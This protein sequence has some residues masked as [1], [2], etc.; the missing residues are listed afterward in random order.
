MKSTSIL[1]LSLLSPPSTSA[2]HLRTQPALDV[3]T[4]SKQDNIYQ[5]LFAAHDATVLSSTASSSSPH[6]DITAPRFQSTASTSSSNIALTPLESSIPACVECEQE[7]GRLAGL[8]SPLPESPYFSNKNPIFNPKWGS[9]GHWKWLHQAGDGDLHHTSLLKQGTT[10]ERGANYG[11]A[12]KYE[13]NMWS[14]KGTMTISSDEVPNIM[15]LSAAIAAAADVDRRYVSIRE[16][17]R[18]MN[19]GVDASRANPVIETSVQHAEE[20]MSSTG[21]SDGSSATGV[22]LASELEKGTEETEQQVTEPEHNTKVIAE[23][24]DE[25][26]SETNSETGVDGTTS[27]TATAGSEDVIA[28]FPIAADVTQSK[29]APLSPAQKM[30]GSVVESAVDSAKAEIGGLIPTIEG[31]IEK[32]EKELEGK[33]EKAEESLVPKDAPIHNN[34]EQEIASMTAS[35][36]SLQREVTDGKTATG[37]SVAATTSLVEEGALDT[38][39]ISVAPSV[40]QCLPLEKVPGCKG[41]GKQYRSATS[42]FVTEKYDTLSATI[43][44][45]APFGPLLQPMLGGCAL[46]VI[47]EQAC[48]VLFPPCDETCSPVKAS[49]QSCIDF[50]SKECLTKESI[51][52]LK[53][54]AAMAQGKTEQF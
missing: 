10:I 42:S 1:L 11:V 14:V 35:L 49:S 8:S 15:S 29:S 46:D 50:N 17:H 51:N 48:L 33:L 13:K 3:A 52:A 47:L 9:H 54:Q 30:I 25:T 38:A 21:T 41:A 27:A 31:E 7:K 39:S 36:N 16:V 26:N 34:P 4:F 37:R 23:A 20:D 24:N 45:A 40:G 12:D 44:A 32:Q 43:N 6:Q 18:D 22:E 19:S 5:N 53:P 28:E 2:K